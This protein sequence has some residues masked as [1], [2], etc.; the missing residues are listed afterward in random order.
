VTEPFDLKLR[1]RRRD[2]AARIGAQLFLLDRTFEDCLDRLSLIR[3]TFDSALL[4]GCPNPNWAT[5][6]QCSYENVTIFD[7]GALFASAASGLQANEE[8]LPVTPG[9]FDLIIA[10]G[11]LD[12]ANRLNDALL[13]LRLALRPG[14]LLLGAI[15][16]GETLPRLRAAMRAADDAVGAATPH[17]HP[18]VDPPGLAALLNAAGLEMPVVDVDRVQ[19]SYPAL[20]N[21]VRDLRG[22]GA[23]NIL[24]QRGRAALPR[25][26]VAAAERTFQQAGNGSKTVELF[27]ILH[28]AGWAP[29]DGVGAAPDQ[30]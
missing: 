21:L 2:R 20:A 30:A 16:G 6:L 3:R 26:A 23:T 11:T 14:G 27:E 28:F 5:R 9:T 8:D 25:S 13:R 15:A 7:P 22:M 4:L 17:L 24:S 19:V 10:I 12:T 1:A 29:A 18:R